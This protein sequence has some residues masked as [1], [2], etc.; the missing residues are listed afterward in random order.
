MTGKSFLAN[1]IQV[2]PD[3]QPVVKLLVLQ[4]VFIGITN[5]FNNTLAFVL[6]LQE[7][8]QEN[9]SLAYLSM[10]LMLPLLT[11]ILLSVTDLLPLRRLLVFTLVFFL[12]GT[13]LLR[14]GLAFTF[15]GWVILL[16]PGWYMA[17]NNFGNTL[18]WTTAGQ[19]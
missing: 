19:L 13:V 11:V 12:A 18:M 7:F 5:V 8:K 14:L 16:L 15:G 1:L 10:G 6:F 4:Y 2:Q 9:I 17:Q 3:E